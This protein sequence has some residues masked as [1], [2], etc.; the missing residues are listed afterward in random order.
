MRSHIWFYNKILCQIGEI[1]Y[2]TSGERM[3]KG[4]QETQLRGKSKR[5]ECVPEPETIHVL[6]VQ[7]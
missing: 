5:E 3:Q 2:G 6:G 1:D 4:G 7:T